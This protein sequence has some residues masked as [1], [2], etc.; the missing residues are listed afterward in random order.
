MYN[1]D[2]IVIV[3]NAFYWGVMS[4]FQAVAYEDL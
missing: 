2:L 1:Y 4:K 3:C